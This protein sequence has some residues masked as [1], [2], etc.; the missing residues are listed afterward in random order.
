MY[1]LWRITCGLCRIQ[2]AAVRAL[3]G[4]RAAVGVIVPREYASG[5]PIRQKR[6]LRLSD[7]QAYRLTPGHAWA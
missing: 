4:H 3:K 2:H 5:S 7:A 1:L 6:C